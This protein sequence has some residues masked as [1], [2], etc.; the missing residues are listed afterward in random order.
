MEPASEFGAQGFGAE[1]V[2]P[3][4]KLGKPKNADSPAVRHE[5]G[6]LEEM[7]SQSSYESEQA[8]RVAKR[9]HPCLFFGPFRGP[10]HRVPDDDW[11]D[12]NHDCRIVKRPSAKPQKPTLTRLALIWIIDVGG[13]RER[14]RRSLVMLRDNGKKQRSA[15]QKRESSH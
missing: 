3:S 5:R 10:S 11:A 12:S 6:M 7:D 14:L 13:L 1:G 4:K 9:M 2:K 15:F 8:H